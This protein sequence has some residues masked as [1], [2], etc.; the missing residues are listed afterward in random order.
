MLSRLIET[1][2]RYLSAPVHSS[3]SR[4]GLIT[5]EVVEDVYGFVLRKVGLKPIL[6]SA[7]AET[8]R[9]EVFSRSLR[10]SGSHDHMHPADS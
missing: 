8:S 2:F 6:S 3:N 10:G 5:L 1:Q 4:L 9:S 7:H